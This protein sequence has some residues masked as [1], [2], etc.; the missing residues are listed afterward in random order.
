MRLIWEDDHTLALG[1]EPGPKVDENASVSVDEGIDEFPNDLGV[2]RVDVKNEWVDAMFGPAYFSRSGSELDFVV[3]PG[4]ISSDGGSVQDG[5][6]IPAVE[7]VGIA[8]I[9]SFVSY[10]AI[11]PAGAVNSGVSSPPSA[12]LPGPKPKVGVTLSRI[13]LGLYVRSI[14]TFGEAYSAGVMPGSILVD[15]NGMG[16]LG[17]S[18][19]KLLGRL[20]QYEGHSNAGGREYESG[21]S[22]IAAASTEAS[23]AAASGDKALGIAPAGGIQGPVALRFIRNGRVYSV[24]LFSKAPFGISWAPCGN[25]ALVQKTYSF[26]EAAGVK[27]GCLVAT[28][29]GRSFRDMDHI[30]TVSTLKDLFTNGEKIKL[31]LVF[32]PSASRTSAFERGS[33][34]A[35][36]DEETLKAGM[37]EQDGVKLKR[38]TS[39]A[40]SNGKRSRHPL[41]NFLSCG[42]SAQYQPE[43]DDL[44]SGPGARGIAGS[45]SDLANQVASGVALAPSGMGKRSGSSMSSKIHYAR[46]PVL[47]KANL[48]F[49]WNALQALVYCITYHMAGCN[50]DNFRILGGFVG[51]PRGFPPDGAFQHLEAPHSPAALVKSLEDGAL[52]RGAGEVFAWHLIQ[53]VTLLSSQEFVAAIKDELFSVD[54]EVN[55]D[56]ISS[57]ELALLRHLEEKIVKMLVGL[58]LENDELCQ[59]LNYLLRSFLSALEV[60]NPVDGQGDESSTYSP[61]RVLRNAQENLSI[62][63]Q[64]RAQSGVSPSPLQELRNPKS[65]MDDTFFEDLKDSMLDPNFLSPGKDANIDTPKKKKAVRKKIGRLLRTGSARKRK[66][67]DEASEGT[68]V[69][70][71]SPSGSDKGSVR[72]DVMATA[73]LVTFFNNM[74]WFVDE[75]ELTCK[76]IEGTLLKSISQKIAKLALQPWSTSKGIAMSNGTVEMRKELHRMNAEGRMDG[77]LPRLPLL[78]PLDASE[79]LVSLVPEECHILPSAHFP[80]LLTF[81]TEARE[82]ESNIMPISI[83]SN[84]GEID[85]QETLYRTTIEVIAVHGVDESEET[86]SYLVH[87]ALAGV[88]RETERSEVGPTSSACRWKDGNLLTFETLSSWGCPNTLSLRLSSSNDIHDGIEELPHIGE[89]ERQQNSSDAGYCWIDLSSTWEGA[90]KSSYATTN[91]NALVSPF[92]GE[93]EFDHSGYSVLPG[94][95]SKILVVELRITCNRVHLGGE[96]SPSRML[97]YKHDDDMRQEMLAL[98]FIEACDRVLRAS[99]L[100]LK[101]KTYRCQSV[102]DRKGFVEWVTGTVALSEICKPV[103]SPFPVSRNNSAAGSVSLSVHSDKVSSEDVDNSLMPRVAGSWSK[104]ESLRSSGPVE[105]LSKQRVLGNIY[106]FNPVQDF[107]RASAYDADAPYFIRKDVMDIYVRSCAG[108]SVITYLL[109]VGDRHLDN[110]L[111]HPKGYFL[112]CDYSFILG[113]DPKTYLPMRITEEMVRGMG[114]RESDNFA[115]FLSLAG[116]AFVALR[117]HSNVRLLM[118]LVRNVSSADLPDVSRNQ[119]PEDAL[120]SMRYRFRLDL[121]EAAA[122]SFIER[123]IESSISSKMWMA[124]D[125]LHTIGKRF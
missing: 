84:A 48:V 28:V 62:A 19:H 105:K 18:S 34:K 13:P 46:C 51:F 2:F 5:A 72:S 120:L 88:V 69:F 106:G 82:S 102:S 100:D 47:P 119:S 15:I 36:I 33:S 79:M 114:G 68:D 11:I 40:A 22:I 90:R 95:D 101:L 122:L 66:N 87:A 112:H 6:Y 63:L 86:V 73:S 37:R 118:A 56:I 65:P 45:L 91:C 52:A 92:T 78:N 75:L 26:A 50:E 110:L 55:H 77:Y 85:G 113:Q 7:G 25:F 116:A 97:L 24:M 29:N 44:A 30:G 43:K 14:D 109:G 96:L 74:A 111:L 61:L 94:T 41:E 121:E 80:L 124:V 39:I 35:K 115:K 107:L 108:Y 76:T 21:D 10:G 71:T 31:Q 27:R 123:L 99:G 8:G 23:T 9:E 67:S 125:A 93:D 98:E 49:R 3:S 12:P 89:Q 59:R 1:P 20:W 117:R 83:P 16:V 81:K 58:A 57:S 17:E 104:Y 103:G 60:D 53:I 54:S 4:A 42:T 70:K 64:E 38:K 32:T